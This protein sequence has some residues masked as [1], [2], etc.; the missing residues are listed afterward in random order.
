MDAGAIGG[1]PTG[2]VSG[3][4]FSRADKSLI[5]CHP[6]RTLVRGGFAFLTSSATSLTGGK[7]TRVRWPER[8]D[9]DG[10]SGKYSLRGLSA[11]HCIYK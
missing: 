6:S 4:D 9:T 7:N 2:F 1:V 11:S 3:H 10:Y 5:F 8:H